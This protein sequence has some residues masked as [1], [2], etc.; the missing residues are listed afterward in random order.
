MRANWERSCKWLWVCVCVCMCMCVSVCTL[1]PLQPRSHSVFVL[2]FVCLFKFAVF[3]HTKHGY[4]PLHL[5]EGTCP[6]AM[7]KSVQC[8]SAAAAAAAGAPRWCYSGRAAECWC[9]WKCLT[10]WTFS[11]SSC[12]WQSSRQFSITFLTSCNLSASCHLLSLYMA[13]CNPSVQ[14]G[15]NVACW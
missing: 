12:S 4:L 1:L 10:G 6:L 14:H 3:I 13:K 9:S 11:H 2:G 7:T 15:R 8:H 5:R